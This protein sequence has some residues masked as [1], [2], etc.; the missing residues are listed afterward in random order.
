M[1]AA[2]VTKYSFDISGEWECLTNGRNPCIVKVQRQPNGSHV[3][4]HPQVNKGMKQSYRDLIRPDMSL[5]YEGFVGRAVP[6]YMAPCGK[7]T[8]HWSRGPDAVEWRR[9]GVKPHPTGGRQP[10]ATESA[11]P[12][13]SGERRPGAGGGGGADAWTRF[14]VTEA[15]MRAAGLFANTF[16]DGSVADRRRTEVRENT[17]T[18]VQ[19]ELKLQRWGAPPESVISLPHID[20]LALLLDNSN[21]AFSSPDALPSAEGGMTL[22]R[23]DVLAVPG[24]ADLD[25]K[26][27]FRHPVRGKDKPFLVLH[28]AALNVGESASTA[29]DWPDYCV[30][31]KLDE[32]RYVEDMGRI[33]DNVMKS[34]DML[35]IKHLVWFPFGMGAFLRHLGIHDP[36]FAGRD[37]AANAPHIE[38]RRALCRRFAESLFHRRGFKV[39]LALGPSGAGDE[40]DVNAD[41]FVRALMAKGSVDKEKLEICLHAD[42]LELSQQLAEKFHPAQVGM[43][44]GTNRRLIGNHWFEEGAKRAIDENLHRRS[45]W[46]AAYAYVLNHRVQSRETDNNNSN[47]QGTTNTLEW[48]VQALGGKVFQLC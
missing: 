19:Q 10:P 2:S 39:Y 46:L 17:K 27:Q 8:V 45:W 14:L 21:Y 41:A 25:S 4:E 15:D 20:E 5:E 9:A 18:K 47:Q 48:Q 22:G 1:A 6:S 35:K 33:F 32:S 34:A 26:W 12:H 42:A 24:R 29:S 3:V 11:R 38:L 28:A 37:I 44:N 43:V 36:R 30:D 31:G 40:A 13:A 23:F 16:P 7:D